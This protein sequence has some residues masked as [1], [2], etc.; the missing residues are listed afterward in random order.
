[1]KNSEKNLTKPEKLANI[2]YE[3]IVRYTKAN[4]PQIREETT[5]LGLDFSAIERGNSTCKIDVLENGNE[6][7]KR[8]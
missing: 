7:G 5:D 6:F 4:S 3:A 1:M 8:R 2:I